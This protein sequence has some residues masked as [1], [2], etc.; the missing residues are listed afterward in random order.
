MHYVKSV[1][2]RMK[3]NYTFISCK[4]IQTFKAKIK[5]IINVL[6]GGG[7]KEEIE[8]EQD[9]DCIFLFGVNEKCENQNIVNVFF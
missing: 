2:K 4:E 6:L 3:A 9:W 1:M 8:N 5:I 7:G